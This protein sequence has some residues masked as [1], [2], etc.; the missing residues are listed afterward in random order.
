MTAGG[1]RG[2][3]ALTLASVGI[4]NATGAAEAPGSMGRAA[5]VSGSLGASG[6]ACLCSAMPPSTI[7]PA[8]AATA[9]LR[10][11]LFGRSLVPAL[12]ESAPRAL[13]PEGVSAA[14]GRVVV[15]DSGGCAAMLRETGEMEE[16]CHIPVTRVSETR[17]SLLPKGARAVARSAALA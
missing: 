7:L 10:R 1:V 6:A 17:A 11:A 3:A 8:A 2:A 5:A 12:T 16:A 13:L 9:Q 15:H 4:G 14:T